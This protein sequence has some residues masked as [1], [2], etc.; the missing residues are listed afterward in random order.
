MNRISSGSIYLKLS[1]LLFLIFLF[2]RSIVIGQEVIMDK[3]VTKEMFIT[4]KGPNT[5]RFTHV[6]LSLSTFIKTSAAQADP[7]YPG[8]L[9]YCLGLR[10]KY[11]IAE[12]YALGYEL[13]YRL[14][15][16]R[17]AKIHDNLTNHDVDRILGNSLALSFFQRFNFDKRGNYIGKF[18]DMGIYGEL[19]FST[20]NILIDHK[21]TLSSGQ[22]K[23]VLTGLKYLNFMNYGLT[24]RL[25]YNRL[26]LFAMY[27]L[28]DV[29]KPSYNRLDLPRLNVGLQIGIHK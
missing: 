15:N 23:L 19:P 20:S 13:E 4:K 27:R 3:R 21:D 7:K 25:G 12:W 11:K 17:Y 2:C 8:S 5:L 24:L 10:T 18:M 16:F 29:F 28:S 22:Q 9:L 6:Y 1:L 14:S 26:V